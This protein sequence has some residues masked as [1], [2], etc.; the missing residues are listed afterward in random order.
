MSDIE[1]RIKAYMDTRL[2]GATGYLG[3]YDKTAQQM[4]RR[5]LQTRSAAAAGA[6]LIPLVSNLTW[7]PHIGGVTIHVATVG[8]SLIGLAVALILALEG[9]FHFKEKWQN[10][11]GIEQYLLSQKYRFDNGVDEYQSLSIEAAFKLFVSKVEKAILDVS[12][13]TLEILGRAEDVTATGSDK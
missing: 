1:E 4:K 13:V 7:E 9:V 2:T 5:H 6:V 12:N 3:Y 8:A 11:R 10:F